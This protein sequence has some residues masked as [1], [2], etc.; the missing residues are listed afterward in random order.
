MA[1]HVIEDFRY[2]LNLVDSEADLPPNGTFSQL[3]CSVD[4]LGLLGK[5][6]GCASLLQLAITTPTYVFYSKALDK[7][8][9]LDG[10]NLKKYSNAWIFEATVKTFSTADK[11]AMVDFNSTSGAKCV[12][13]HKVDGVFDSPDGIT[14]T[15][16]SATVKGTTIAVWHNKL[17]VGG[18][19]SNFPRVWWSNAG[20]SATWT[21][22]TD[23]NDLREKDVT[24]LTALHE[25]AGILIA[26][27]ENSAYRINNPQTGE[28]TMIDRAHGASEH[29][30]IASIE[31][32]VGFG[33]QMGFYTSDGNSALV[34]RSHPI[35]PFFQY[36]SNP[37]I[38]V[39]T[40][41]D[42]FLIGTQADAMILEWDPAAGLQLGGG[43]WYHVPGGSRG[44]HSCAGQIG[45]KVIAID[46][47]VKQVYTFGDRA[48]GSDFAAAMPFQYDIAWQRLGVADKVKVR[49]MLVEGRGTID[50]YLKR[51]YD[52][53]TEDAVRTIVMATNANR[54]LNTAEAHSLGVCRSFGMRLYNSSANNLQRIIGSV[55]VYHPPIAIARIR[56]DYLPLSRR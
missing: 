27:K 24:V 13:V 19:T 4:E 18:D 36:A 48:L 50:Y 37:N 23:F 44:M 39:T 52:T 40:L 8:F 11:I 15:N 49:R 35:A 30:S 38:V 22:A 43:W 54:I 31:G 32:L 33:N 53:L 51:D 56:L 55:G 3:N 20:T 47:N 5:R 45:D 14:W 12:L 2:G 42:R 34:E 9:V 10:T 1:S 17:F 6:G 28:Y 7:Y 29:E 16:R 26:A 46:K 41:R 21:T 25:T